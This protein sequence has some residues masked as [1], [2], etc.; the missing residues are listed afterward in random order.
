MSWRRLLSLQTTADI[1]CEPATAGN[2]ANMP[3]TSFTS[4]SSTKTQEV[5]LNITRTGLALPTA[6]L[7]LLP[8]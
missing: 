8:Q 1:V 2:N 6:E 5:K 7:F 4:S 3:C